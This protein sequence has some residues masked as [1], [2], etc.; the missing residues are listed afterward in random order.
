MAR[1]SP[2]A[3]SRPSSAAAAAPEDLAQSFAQDAVLLAQVRGGVA[4]A[5]A[6]A[7]RPADEAERHALRRP[8]V[9]DRAVGDASERLEPVPDRAPRAHVL[10]LLLRPDELLEIRERLD[11]L[12]RGGDR[13]RIELLQP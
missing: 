3:C 5:R 2:R 11:Q 9:S 8:F 1:G 13:E 12:G 10:R 7:P 6:G 4:L